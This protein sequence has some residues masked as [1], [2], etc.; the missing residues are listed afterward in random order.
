MLTGTAFPFHLHVRPR[1]R[2]P[3]SSRLDSPWRPGTKAPLRLVLVMSGQLPV[4]SP[5][6]GGRER[7]RCWHPPFELPPNSGP[8]VPERATDMRHPPTESTPITSSAHLL[9]AYVA[10]LELE[11]DRLR[12]QA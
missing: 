4:G 8:G 3:R 5:W 1:A 2:S 7:E 11:V 6:N 9:L 12:K 10:D